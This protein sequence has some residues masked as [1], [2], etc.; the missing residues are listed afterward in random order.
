METY[1]L[2][3][4]ALDSVLILKLIPYQVLHNNIYENMDSIG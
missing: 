4:K 2:C 1:K 3:P